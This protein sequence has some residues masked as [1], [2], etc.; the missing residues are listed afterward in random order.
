V[1]TYEVHSAGAVTTVEADTWRRDLGTGEV[2]FVVRDHT[3]ADGERE[4][5]RLAVQQPHRSIR[6]RGH[7][8]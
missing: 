4:V 6:R 2:V 7:L 1:H 5:L 8:S 3:A